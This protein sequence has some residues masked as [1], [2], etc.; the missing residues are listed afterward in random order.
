MPFIHFRS[1]FKRCF[2]RLKRAIET[3][4]GKKESTF[5]F[6]RVH[7]HA[8]TF[9]VRHVSVPKLYAKNYKTH[10][11]ALPC[12]FLSFCSALA[13]ARSLCMLWDVFIVLGL[14]F[15][16]A[17]V[18][19]VCF[20]LG[21]QAARR[22]IVDVAVPQHVEAWKKSA[23]L[24]QRK[25]VQHHSSAMPLQPISSG[26]CATPTPQNNNTAAERK[27]ITVDYSRYFKDQ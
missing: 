11:C 19:T 12:V 1:N 10:A 27:L 22:N 8:H 16:T 17:I 25:I 14:F 9:L 2:F 6:A 3:R 24:R 15:W 13:C 23:E 18:G 7:T 4:Q 20:F 5:F 21:I 26:A